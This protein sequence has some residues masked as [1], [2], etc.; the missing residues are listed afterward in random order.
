M[1]FFEFL[2]RNGRTDGQKL[3]PTS[4]HSVFQQNPFRQQDNSDNNESNDGLD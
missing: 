1:Y 2:A 3:S 4:N